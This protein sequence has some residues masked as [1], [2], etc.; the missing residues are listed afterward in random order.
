M[1]KICTLATSNE[2]RP[3]SVLHLNQSDL[4]KIT[5]DTGEYPILS[6]QEATFFL[7]I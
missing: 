6:F 3:V 4:V 1:N 7:R 2:S 5:Y